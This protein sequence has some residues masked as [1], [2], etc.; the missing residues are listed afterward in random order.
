MIEIAV[1][2]DPMTATDTEITAGALGTVI[3]RNI[4]NTPRII[5]FMFP[6]WIVWAER[7]R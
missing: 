7:S 4:K 3:A 2:R 5:P 6:K 1:I